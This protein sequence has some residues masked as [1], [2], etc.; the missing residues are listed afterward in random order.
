MNERVSKI[1]Q[2]SVEAMDL[3]HWLLES[4]DPEAALNAAFFAG[5]READAEQAETLSP[6]PAQPAHDDAQE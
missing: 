2:E 5:I 6:T 4:H 1:R 3:A